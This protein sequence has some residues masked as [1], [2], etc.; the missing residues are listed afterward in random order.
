M[1]LPPQTRLEAGGYLTNDKDIILLV[2]DSLPSNHNL[3]YVASGMEPDIGALDMKLRTAAHGYSETYINYK[4]STRASL[5]DGIISALS[6]LVDPV[7]QVG[8]GPITLTMTWN[9]DQSDVDL[10]IYE[11]NHNHIFYKNMKGTSGYLDLDNIT[12]YGPEHYYTDCNQLQIG[13]YAFGVN[14]FSD[15]YAIEN[16]EETRSTKATIV[17]SVPNSTRTFS[18]TLTQYKLDS[19]D[20]SPFILGKIVVEEITD[21]DDPNQL[22]R[23]KYTIEAP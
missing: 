1:L 22:R 18:K 16:G 9:I 10:H 12:G 5:K 19:G 15:R 20:N 13:E 3:R 11:P 4:Y 6:S 14:Y 23:L 17:A 8:S 2:P 7:A 21:T